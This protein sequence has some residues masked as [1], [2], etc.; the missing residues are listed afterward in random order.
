M[1][2]IYKQD[3]DLSYVQE[4]VEL[5]I[6]SLL[7][8][9]APL[10]IGH[11]QILVGVLVNAALVL[12]ALNVRGYKLL[13]V[14][15]LPSLGVLSR[16]LLFGPFTVFLVYMIP[17]IW[18]GN[19]ILVYAFK[20]FSVSMKLNKVFTLIIGASMKSLFLFSMAYLF[21]NVGVLPVVF[22]TSMGVMQFYTAIAGG[23]VALGVQGVKRK[24]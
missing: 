22:L 5:V 8:F 6:Y 16:G 15:M 11:P 7:C 21:V 23:M 14:I 20:K 24:I 10:M 9:F 13:A 2:Y 4:N 12:N 1:E 19:A 17:F 3:Y 18:V